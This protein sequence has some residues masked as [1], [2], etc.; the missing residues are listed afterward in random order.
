MARITMRSQMHS[1][2]NILTPLKA[3]SLADTHP[4]P[5]VGSCEWRRNTSAVFAALIC[6]STFIT[7]SLGES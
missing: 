1:Y 4:L 2:R 6:R 3:K 5:S 7:L